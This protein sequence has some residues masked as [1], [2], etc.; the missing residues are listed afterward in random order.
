MQKKSRLPSGH[1]SHN[2]IKESS[3]QQVPL[4]EAADC[5]GYTSPLLRLEQQLSGKQNSVV[6]CKLLLSVNFL[7][8]E[9]GRPRDMRHASTPALFLYPV[10][11]RTVGWPHA[12]V[13]ILQ[14]PFLP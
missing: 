9:T 11:I 6:E 1:N 5:N 4:F 8:K 10:H 7:P 14:L 13:C 2:S 12:P 3:S